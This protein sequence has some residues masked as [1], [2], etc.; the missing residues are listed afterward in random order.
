MYN[1]PTGEEAEE[2]TK[3]IFIHIYSG[4]GRKNGEEKLNVFAI[5]ISH[6]N[7]HKKE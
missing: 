6:E 4:G 3:L 5:I 7:P 2:E 1:V